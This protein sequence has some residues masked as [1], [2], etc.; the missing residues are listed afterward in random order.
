MTDATRLMD[1][2]YRRRARQ[3]AHRQTTDAASATI[4][5]LVVGIGTERYGIELAALAE[6]FPYRGCTAVP[7]ATPALLG[8]MNARGDIRAVVDLRRVLELPA[9]DDGAA[10]YVVMLRHGGGAIGLRID[11]IDQ[12]RHIDLA[13]LTSAGDGAATIPGSRFVKALTTDTIIVIDTIAV[14][15]SLGLASRNSDGR[16]M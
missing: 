12:V 2:V 3:L 4:A 1:D 13:Q 5:V 9:G 10:G 6:V 15:S 11:A 8:V 16:R 7:G 14:L